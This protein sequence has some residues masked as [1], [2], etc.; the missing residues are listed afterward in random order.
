MSK[1]APPSTRSER[2]ASA[3]ASSLTGRRPPPA[4]GGP[5][6][7]APEPGRSGTT[8]TM[9]RA[10]ASGS[11]ATGGN[12]GGG[13]GRGGSGRA[14]IR[15]FRSAKGAFSAERRGSSPASRPRRRMRS[16]LAGPARGVES[17]RG[18]LAVLVDVAERRAALH[19]ELLDG[20]PRE[21]A[22]LH[23]PVLPPAHGREG[24]AE[25]LG[26][27]FLGQ[28]DLPAPRPD[29]PPRLRRRGPHLS[30]S[31]WRHASKD[32]SNPGATA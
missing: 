14:R 5:S 2:S 19:R 13:A 20:L 11:S 15:F 4:G 25:R 7:R 10:K 22:R 3:S 29:D 27:P 24:H 16:H 6:T 1:R 30:C 8:P 31:M 32:G 21:L 9:A 17:L 26:E 12:G 23:V 18:L 28:P